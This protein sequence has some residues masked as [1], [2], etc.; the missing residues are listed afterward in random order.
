M[1]SKIED[2]NGKHI[3]VTIGVL[4]ESRG[5]CMCEKL[6]KYFITSIDNIQVRLRELT[7]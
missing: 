1:A 3:T 7:R 4:V 2:Y 5:Q 6:S